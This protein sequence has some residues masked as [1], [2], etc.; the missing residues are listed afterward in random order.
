MNLRRKYQTCPFCET[1][2]GKGAIPRPAGQGTRLDWFH[3]DCA[4][5]SFSLDIILE[6]A[7]WRIE[8]GK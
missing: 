2:V 5:L 3:T 1:P 8:H 6:T 7:A 4:H